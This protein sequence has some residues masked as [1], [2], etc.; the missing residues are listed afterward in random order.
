MN[1]WVLETTKNL[2]PQELLTSEHQTTLGRLYLAN[3]DLRL[4]PKFLIHI[5][6]PLDPSKIEWEHFKFISTVAM[7]KC[8]ATC[9][10]CPMG[11]HFP[12]V[13]PFRATLAITLMMAKAF[14]S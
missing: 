2:F 1:N 3:D 4:G 12:I 14:H 13:S 10:V 11:W 5:N 7:K 6:D 8:A 9:S